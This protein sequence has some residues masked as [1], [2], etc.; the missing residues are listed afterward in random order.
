MLLEKV[1][2]DNISSVV[3]CYSKFKNS[4]GQFTEAKLR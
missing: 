4:W 3:M 2:L 1:P